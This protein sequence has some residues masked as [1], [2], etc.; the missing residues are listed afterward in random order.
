MGVTYF[1][2]VLVANVN[3]LVFS[4]GVKL[5]WFGRLRLWSLLPPICTH[6]PIYISLTLLNFCA[7]MENKSSRYVKS[8]EL[9]LWSVCH[10]MVLFRSILTH[11]LSTTRHWITSWRGSVCC[12]PP[13]NFSSSC[14][15]NFLPSLVPQA[16]YY[17][18]FLTFY[19]FYPTGFLDNIAI[20]FSFWMVSLH[21]LKTRS[22]SSTLMVSEVW[23]TSC[24]C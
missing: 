5:K 21:Y 18:M 9:L 24:V 3:H 10:P 17:F 20:F 14:P 16:A 8:S 19:S 13:M 6:A 22:G 23:L 12:K 2:K 15:V 4:H 7:H 1:R 11:I